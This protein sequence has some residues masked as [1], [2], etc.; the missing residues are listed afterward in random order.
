MLQAVLIQLHRHALRP[1]HVGDL[2]HGGLHRL[3]AAPV[4]QLDAGKG[5]H[6]Q[7]H[8]HGNDIN[9]VEFSDTLCF[10]FHNFLHNGRKA[11]SILCGQD[12]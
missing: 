12:S 1:H 5:Q 8:K 6:R 4:R 2:G 7:D 3:T 9:D 10:F 11:R